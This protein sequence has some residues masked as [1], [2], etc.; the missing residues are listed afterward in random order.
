MGHRICDTIV[1][2]CDPDSKKIRFFEMTTWI[3]NS[4][5]IIKSFSFNF[6]LKFQRNHSF[7]FIKWVWICQKIKINIWEIIFTK[8]LWWN[9]SITAIFRVFYAEFRANRIK[10]Y[11]VN[12]FL[13]QLLV[14]SIES[15]HSYLFDTLQKG[16]RSLFSSVQPCDRN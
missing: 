2:F 16:H 5:L 3:W 9:F 15:K 7:Y 12:Y 1:D 10:K 13:W 8:F 4:K 14:N 11:F 6:Y